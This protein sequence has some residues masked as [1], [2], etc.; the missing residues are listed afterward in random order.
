MF[1]STRFLFGILA[2]LALSACGDPRITETGTAK[3]GATPTPA[4]PNATPAPTATPAEPESTTRVHGVDVSEFQGT[5]AWSQVKAAGKDFA[6]IRVS[7][8][9]GHFDTEF[10]NNWHKAKVA[11]LYRGVYQFFRASESGKAQADLLL[12]KTG[13]DLG[14]LPPTLDVE[15]TDGASD[16][17]IRA[18]IVAWATEIRQ[19]TG[20]NPIVYT[21]PGFWSQIG[22]GPSQTTLWVAHWGVANP[23]VPSSWMDWTFWQ[24][25]DVGSVNGIAGHV[26][27]DTFHGSLEDLHEYIATGAIQNFADNNDWY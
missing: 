1:K 25:T 17:T 19:K 10:T 20:T 14:D 12:S 8:G 2:A 16:A 21:S 5:I 15:V 18:G 6:F 27:L 24:Y 13:S 23:T 22:Y 26:D 9:T 7:D 3:A 4:D 11:G